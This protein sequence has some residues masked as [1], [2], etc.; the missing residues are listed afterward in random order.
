MR[1]KRSEDQKIK[2]SEGKAVDLWLLARKKVKRKKGKGKSCWIHEALVVVPPS[3]LNGEKIN[4]YTK[5]ETTTSVYF[6]GIVWDVRWEC[7]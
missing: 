7:R 6:C 5:I 4:L 1:L 2:R 3:E